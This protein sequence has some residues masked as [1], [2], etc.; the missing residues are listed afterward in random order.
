[1]NTKIYNFKSN[2]AIPKECEHVFE[3][4]ENIQIILLWKLIK[5]YDLTLNKELFEKICNEF[6]NFIEEK[7]QLNKKDEWTITHYNS[8]N[9]YAELLLSFEYFKFGDKSFID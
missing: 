2:G 4:D 6:E 3:Y 1:M 5:K 9:I 7:F 8:I